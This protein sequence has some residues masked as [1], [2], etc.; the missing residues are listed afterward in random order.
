L[1]K[2]IHFSNCFNRYYSNQDVR[3]FKK[4][5]DMIFSHAFTA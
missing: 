4:K 2:E 3:M 5:R 1:L